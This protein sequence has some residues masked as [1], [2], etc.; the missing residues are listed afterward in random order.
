MYQ[1]LYTLALVFL[2][3]TA[4]W[5]WFRRKTDSILSDLEGQITLLKLR[6]QDVEE[7]L[8]SLQ[9]DLRQKHILDR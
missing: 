6:L 5:A 9:D 7:Q 8:N 1:S 3:A 2:V 4:G